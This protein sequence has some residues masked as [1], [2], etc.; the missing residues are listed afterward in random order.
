MKDFYILILV[1]IKID[2]K[3][4]DLFQNIFRRGVQ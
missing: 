1:F 2:F 3:N 4:Q